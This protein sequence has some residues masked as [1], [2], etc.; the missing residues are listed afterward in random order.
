[1]LLL[2]QVFNSLQKIQLCLSHKSTLRFL[3]VAAEEYDEK[4]HRWREFLLERTTDPGN[5]VCVILLC[6]AA[7]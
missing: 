7:N 2:M 5:S 1:M 4:V 3:D 6:T